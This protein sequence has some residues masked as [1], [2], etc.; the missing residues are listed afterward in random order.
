MIKIKVDK[1]IIVKKLLIVNLFILLY[2]TFA[3]KIAHTA[4]LSAVWCVLA[5]SDVST[6]KKF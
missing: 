5:P 1:L 4:V 3:H 6:C 2:R